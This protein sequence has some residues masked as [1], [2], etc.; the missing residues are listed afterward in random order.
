MLG[1]CCD[2]GSISAEGHCCAATAQRASPP[3]LLPLLLP[4]LLLMCG[5]CASAGRVRG[6]TSHYNQKAVSNMSKLVPPAASFVQ[7]ARDR[8]AVWLVTRAFSRE[9][10][11]NLVQD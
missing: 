4:L 6:A 10:S 2:G 8:A 11:Q 7:S 9:W 3:P 1:V 5:W